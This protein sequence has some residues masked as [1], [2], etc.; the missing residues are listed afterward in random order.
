VRKKKLDLARM[1]LGKILKVEAQGDYT[2]TV[3]EAVRLVNED[4]RKTLEAEISTLESS[5]DMFS[6]LN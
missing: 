1:N 5:R 6:Q 3:P 4:K 2:E